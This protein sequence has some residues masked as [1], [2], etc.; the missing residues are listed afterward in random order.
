MDWNGIIQVAF[1][2]AL[3][4][5]S[6]IIKDW[7]FTRKE[8]KKLKK[9][10][11]QNWIKSR[12]E[13]YHNFLRVFSTPYNEDSQIYLDA[14]LNAS[15]FGELVLL[16]PIKFEDESI[17]SLKDL[18]RVILKLRNDITRGSEYRRNILLLKATSPI[19]P[20]QLNGSVYTDTTRIEN[21]EKT[22]KSLIDLDNENIVGRL[23]KLRT[24]AADAFNSPI[25]NSLETSD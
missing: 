6:D 7:Y 3:I 13:S 16:K 19:Y 24:I 11:R 14:V 25:M 9:D 5:I 21:F 20:M 22:G 8:E 4:F 1:G 18:S 17:G 15:E 12:K 10:E 2:A 23:D